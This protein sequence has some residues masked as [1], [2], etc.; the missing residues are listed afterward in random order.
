LAIA[1]LISVGISTTGVARAQSVQGYVVGAVGTDSRKSADAPSE[2][3]L[4][5]A[6]GGGGELLVQDRFGIVADINQVSLGAASVALNGV[7]HFQ[8]RPTQRI[9][10]HV[11]AG[12]AHTTGDRQGNG[13]NFSVGVNYWRWRRVAV[14]AEFYERLQHSD[15]R[16]T[17]YTYGSFTEPAYT[18][19]YRVARV[20]VSFR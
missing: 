3:F 19:R 1:V 7:W 6:V 18:E 11:M 8:R 10:P 5:G 16:Q 20:G 12:Y 9:V 13:A 2:S 14:R 4:Y 17:G 15:A